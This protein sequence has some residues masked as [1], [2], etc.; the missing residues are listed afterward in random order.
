MRRSTIPVVL[1][2][3]AFALAS[4]VSGC[5]TSTEPDKQQVALAEEETA[6]PPSVTREALMETC[7]FAPSIEEL[8]ALDSGY[9]LF[10]IEGARVTDTVRRHVSGEPGVLQIAHWVSWTRATTVRDGRPSSDGTGAWY[11]G[12]ATSDSSAVERERSRATHEGIIEPMHSASLER[13]RGEL[14][15]H[16]TFLGIVYESADGTHS[17]ISRT[18]PIHDGRVLLSHGEISLV[19]LAPALSAMP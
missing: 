11:F 10:L 18:L 5:I 8:R 19:E 13:A 17:V 3:C 14:E 16:S 7:D 4:A 12:G 1:H 9:E 2:G 6:A 15:R